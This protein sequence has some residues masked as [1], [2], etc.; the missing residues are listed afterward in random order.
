MNTLRLSIQATAYTVSVC[1]NAL[2]SSLGIK[3]AKINYVCV[4]SS[5]LMVPLRRI[6]GENTNTAQTKFWMNKKCE[7]I[8][9]LVNTVI[10]LSMKVTTPEY[11]IFINIICL[12]H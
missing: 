4:M 10:H 9:T 11:I 12:P 5:K 2:A 8:F 7:N 3:I 1:K 6:D